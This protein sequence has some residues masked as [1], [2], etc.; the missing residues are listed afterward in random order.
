MHVS[1]EG[2]GLKQ[3]SEIMKTEFIPDTLLPLRESL[4]NSKFKSRRSGEG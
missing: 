3:Y 1:E 4:S 2:Q